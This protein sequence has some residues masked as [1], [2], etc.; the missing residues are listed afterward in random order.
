MQTTLSTRLV[1]LLL[2][3]LFAGGAAAQESEPPA[4]PVEP[5][6]ADLQNRWWAYFQGTKAEVTPRKNQ[7]LK[8]VGVQIADLA[9]QR[10]RS[11]YYGQQIVVFG[12]YTKPGPVKLRLA[13]RISGEEL[14]WET[15]FEL[16]ERYE[17][18]VGTSGMYWARLWSWG[19]CSASICIS[20]SG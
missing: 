13:G 15:E 17:K 10:L 6:L 8:N 12:R 18:P 16:P 14:T 5:E 1:I 2:G 19:W 11:V 4:E 9:P 20:V 3:V 7:F